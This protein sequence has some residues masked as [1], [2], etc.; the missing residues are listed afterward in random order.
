MSLV[1]KRKIMYMVNKYVTEHVKDG[2]QDH[3]CYVVNDQ[4]TL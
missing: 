1:D 4:H 3:T 2:F